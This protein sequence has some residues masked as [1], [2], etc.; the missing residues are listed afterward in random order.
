M[1]LYILIVSQHSFCIPYYYYVRSE[2]EKGETGPGNKKTLYFSGSRELKEKKATN[3][4]IQI[5]L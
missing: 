2:V 3:R 4:K 5:I 1:T